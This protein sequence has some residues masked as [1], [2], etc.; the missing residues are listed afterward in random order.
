MPIGVLQKLRVQGL[1][2]DTAEALV[3]ALEIPQVLRKSFG[4]KHGQF[5]TLEKEISGE[6]VRRPYSICSQAMLAPSSLEIGIKRVPGGLFSSWAHQE[7][8]VGD[9]IDVL[10]PAG[11]FT[12]PINAECPRYYCCIAIGSGITPIMS[13]IR[14]VLSAEPLSKVVL[15]YGNRRA[16]SA[17]FLD[18]IGALKNRYMKRLLIH[19]MF[20]RE[21]GTS[22]LLSGRLKGKSVCRIVDRTFQ[23]LDTVEYFICGPEQVALEIQDS[24]IETGVSAPLIHRELFGLVGERQPRDMTKVDTEK[25]V[26]IVFKVFNT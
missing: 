8:S 23:K 4:F 26:A 18:E 19:H 17:M 6:T 15:I 3:V 11:D 2:K 24:L 1:R 21:T 16:S 10:P 22:E 25:D 12:S 5:L 7:L 14:T 13:V 20:S 9:E